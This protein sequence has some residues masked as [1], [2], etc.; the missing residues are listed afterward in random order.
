MHE[1][2]SFS[3]RLA[4]APFEVANYVAAHEVA[5]LKIKGTL[6][7]SD[8]PSRGCTRTTSTGTFG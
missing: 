4:I 5:H 1:S 3:W 7:I 6:T 8:K 2:L